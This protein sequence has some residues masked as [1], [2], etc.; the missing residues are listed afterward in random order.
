M[1]AISCSKTFSVSPLVNLELSQ[2]FL[3]IMTSLFFCNHKPW[4][5]ITVPVLM[6]GE[7]GLLL[8][9]DCIVFFSKPAI[10]NIFKI[11]NYLSSCAVG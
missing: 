4:S 5:Y 11:S 8:F 3:L 10:I 1:M 2:Q 7:F 9:L 6:I